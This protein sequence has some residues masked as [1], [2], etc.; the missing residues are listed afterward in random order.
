MA[1]ARK[2]LRYVREGYLR[3]DPQGTA[4]ITGQ[5][6]AIKGVEMQC[7]YAF[8]HQIAAELGAH[9]SGQQVVPGTTV[10]LGSVKGLVDPSGHR[11]PTAGRELARRGPVD[12]RQ[13]ARRDG[14]ID[15]GSRA[16]IPEAQ[17]GVCFEK[18]LRDRLICPSLKLAL[19]PVHVAL[20]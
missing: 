3:S 13:D 9:G 15:P 17:K 11:G 4:D 10:A 5:V 7:V 14:F 20:Q 6:R 19:E 18:E 16:S 12:D 2:L 1:S 8:V